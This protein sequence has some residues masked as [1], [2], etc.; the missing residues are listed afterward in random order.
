MEALGAAAQDRG[1]AGFQAQRRRVRR[2]VG[3]A[4]VNDADDTERHRDALNLE[5]VRTLPFG[6]HPAERIGQRSNGLDAR[7]HAVDPAL[8]EHQPI[9]QRCAQA[10]RLTGSHVLRVGREYRLRIAPDRIGCRLQGAIAIV[11]AALCEHRHG[12]PCGGA[13]SVHRPG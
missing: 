1:I 12:A 13:H 5:A 11:I 7:C 4:L 2:D 6:E 10:T 8:V 3:A 9:E